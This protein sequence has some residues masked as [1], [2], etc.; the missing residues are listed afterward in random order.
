MRKTIVILLMLTALFPLTA[1]N[2]ENKQKFDNRFYVGVDLEGRFLDLNHFMY[3]LTMNQQFHKHW[4]YE[5]GAYGLTCGKDYV[6]GFMV[7]VNMVFYSNAVN[8]SAGVTFG[9]LVPDEG[10]TL[11]AQL[12]V[13][14]M[15]QVAP[16]WFVEPA[17]GF[18]YYYDSSFNLGCGVNVKYSI[19]EWKK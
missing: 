15:I 4:G 16:N 9:Y 11:G 1:Q 12:E 19:P 14:K 13:S 18:N 8:L 5:I 7:P 6:G 17:I 2:M 10:I 3:G